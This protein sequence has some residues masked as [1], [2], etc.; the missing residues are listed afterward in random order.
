MEG[1]PALQVLKG[2]EV[3]KLKPHLRS[4]GGPVNKMYVYLC[5]FRWT[6][7]KTE[8]QS[9]FLNPCQGISYQKI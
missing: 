6:L 3:K 9:H 5:N 1:E 8:Y 2:A 7:K 4:L